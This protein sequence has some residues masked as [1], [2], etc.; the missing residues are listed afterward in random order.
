MI[1]EKPIF[2]SKSDKCKTDMRK[3]D[4]CKSDMRKTDK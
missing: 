4:M 1:T 2:M 3:I